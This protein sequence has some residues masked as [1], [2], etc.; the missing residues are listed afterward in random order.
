MS[1]SKH[2][3]GQ[4]ESYMENTH[5]ECPHPENEAFSKG[6]DKFKYTNPE[7]RIDF[8]QAENMLLKE[9]LHIYKAKVKELPKWLDSAE[10]VLRD[11]ES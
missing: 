5:T 8:L 3:C 2:T 1:E 10:Q 9:I 7:K 6:C 4:C 11:S